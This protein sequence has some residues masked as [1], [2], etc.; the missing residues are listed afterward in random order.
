MLEVRYNNS[1]KELTAWC[2]DSKQF[3]NLE[4]GGHTVVIL[5]IDIP[6]TPPAAWLY[7][8]ANKQLVPNP[9]YTEPEPLRDFATEI[10]KLGDRI[11]MLEDLVQR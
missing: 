5:D 2:A 11:T 7:D 4:R 9:D 10:D 6:D 1:T 8:K 3:G